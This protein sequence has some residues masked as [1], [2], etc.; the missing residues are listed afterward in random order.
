MWRVH[1]ICMFAFVLGTSFLLG[2]D[3]AKIASGPKV[4][5]FVPMAFECVNING[6][7]K[8]IFVEATKSE[9]AHHVPRPHCLVS[10]FAL[11]PAVLIFTKEPAE[12]KDEPLNDLMKKLDVLAAEFE[13]RGFSVGVVFLSP[14][15]RDSTNN[16]KEDSLE[17]LKK[18]ANDDPA[19][20]EKLLAA[21]AKE[22]IE[23]NVKREKL[24]ERL[25][26]RAE[27]LKHAIVAYFPADGPKKFAL[28]PK[29]E[30][31]VLF[32]ERMKITDN[33][34]FAP[35]Q[36]Q[37]KNVESIEKRIRQALPLKKKKEDKT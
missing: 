8:A 24:Y 32:Y 23:E 2:Q 11:S 34:A 37:L 20:L 30:T 27:P 7:S 35:E 22:L 36:M 4:G 9:P 28:N 15:A 13:D 10:A 5:A 6:P 14:D 33:W 3:D 26:K 1:L 25:K 18:K 21:R 12:G 19:E 17:N 31:T 16:A 29:A